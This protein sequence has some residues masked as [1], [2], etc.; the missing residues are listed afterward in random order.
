M[1]TH[2]GQYQTFEPD[3]ETKAFIYQQVQDLEHGFGGFGNLAVFVEK[4][5]VVSTEDREV[6]EDSFAVTFIVEPDNLNL[7][8]RAEGNDIYSATIAAKEEVK[9]RISALLNAQSMDARSFTLLH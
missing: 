7:K 6:L 8:V 1:N 2:N 5:E 9:R 3:Q 4:E